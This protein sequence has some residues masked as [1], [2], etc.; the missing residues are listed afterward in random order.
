MPAGAVDMPCETAEYIPVGGDLVYSVLHEARGERRGMI[1]L[2][3]TFGGERER[4]YSTGVQ[5]AR[6]MAVRGFDVLRFDYRG[7]G[8][9]TGSFEHM[10]C[11]HWRDDIAACVDCLRRRD[12]HAPVILHGMRLGAVL[13]SGAFAAGLGDAMLLWATISSARAHLWEYL[14]RALGTDLVLDP[15]APRKTREEY[16]ADLE[17]GRHI[18]VDGYFWSGELWS[19]STRHALTLPGANHP[20][21]WRVYE[22]RPRPAPDADAAQPP[23]AVGDASPVAPEPAAPESP[24]A[25]SNANRQVIEAA[26]FFES[27][28]YIIPDCQLLLQASME[29]VESAVAG[30][31]AATSA[32]AA[33]T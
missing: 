10:T 19:D 14:R 8:E 22:V 25:R 28:G 18:N 24:P 33:G 6:R 26:R 23:S 30:D 7:I 12:G 5:W 21:P 1:V 27:A 17:A 20:R 16:L 3:G 29:W 32:K 4:A 31:G 2:A 15:D 11:S 13:M 9:S